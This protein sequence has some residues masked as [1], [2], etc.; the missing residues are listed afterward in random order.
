MDKTVRVC[1]TSVVVMPVR[2]RVLVVMLVV[3]PVIVLCE[4]L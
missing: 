3:V 1:V 2:V 4:W